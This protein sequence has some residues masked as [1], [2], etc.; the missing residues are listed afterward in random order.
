MEKPIELISGVIMSVKNP[1]P[2]TKPRLRQHRTEVIRPFVQKYQYVQLP[3]PAPVLAAEGE[4]DESEGV[5]EQ[6]EAQPQE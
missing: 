6:A 3:L 1:A 4:L 5:L 2:A